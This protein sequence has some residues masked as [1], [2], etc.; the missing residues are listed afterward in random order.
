MLLFVLSAYSQQRGKA[1]F[2]S[3]RATGNRT[4]SGERI[5]HDS[6]TCA[7]RTYTFGTLLKVTNPA[8]G[9]NVIV[10]VTDRGPHGR[11]RII[12][13]SYAAANA[14]G[15]INRGVASVIVEKF[16]ENKGIPFRSDEQDLPEMDFEITE[17]IPQFYHQEQQKTQKKKQPQQ[18]SKS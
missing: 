6:L 16:H 14:L 2:Y 5:H 10:K 13:L 18:P 12:D 11:G 17:P 15:I 9:K 8:N 4:A 3:K 7:H 1:S